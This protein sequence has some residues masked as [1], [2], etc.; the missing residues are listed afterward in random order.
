MEIRRV[1]TGHDPSGTAAVV[2]DGPA[3]RTHDY[4]HI[5]GMSATMVWATAPGQPPTPRIPRRA[6]LS[7]LPGPGGTCFVIVRL[8]PD[9][10]LG[11]A[12]PVA[13]GAEHRMASPGLAERFEPGNPGMH[14]TD[15]VD[16]VLVLDGEIWLDLD[17]GNDDPARPR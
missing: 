3:P 8:P 12:D 2:S 4:R 13:A 16:Y 1:V 14:V 6:C 10:V 15:S 5:P 17:G 9:D 7:Q 11:A